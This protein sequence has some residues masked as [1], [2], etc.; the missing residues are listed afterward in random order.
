MSDEEINHLLIQ[1]FGS[2]SIPGGRLRW[3][4]YSLWKRIF[5]N[6]IVS[7]SHFIKRAFDVLAS[8]VILI[9]ISPLL[10]L[11]ALLIKLEDG[12]AVTFA[13]RRCGK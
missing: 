8:V 4:I 5:W 2:M 9:L 11:V 3:T 13:A 10:A 12:G 1:R 7:S 6:A